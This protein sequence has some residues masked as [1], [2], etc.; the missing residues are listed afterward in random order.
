VFSPDSRLLALPDEDTLRLYSCVSGKAVHT[1]RVPGAVFL[2]AAFAPDGL[3]LA[4]GD[5]DGKLYLWERDTG[6]AV[7]TWQGH[8]FAV[9]A[10]AFAA[11]GR[12]LVS[13]GQDGVIR[14]WDLASG[15]ERTHLDGESGWVY[16]VAFSPDGRT[17]ASGHYNG[18]ALLWDVG[19]SPEGPRRTMPRGGER[20]ALWADL[21]GTDAAKAYRAG[22]VLR[23]GGDSAVALL[24]ERLRPS[25]PVSAERLRRLIADLD[26]ADFRTR[27]DASAELERLGVR[28]EA[29]LRE[30]LDH[31]PSLEARRRLEAL[32]QEA[33][34]RRFAFSAEEVGQRRAVAV[35]GHIGSQDARRLL[36][37]LAEGDPAARQTEAARAAL[38]RLEGRPHASP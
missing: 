20:D 10:L 9:Y 16:S 25:P 7:R 19:P 27:Q 30:A 2:T 3:T 14:L 23:E 17:L 5:L 15:R 26:S 34:R 11:D 24:R 32:L 29:A 35:L 21:T 28:T 37:R 36:Q 33:R 38:R 4:A 6:Q 31:P 13:A 1:A 8:K 12:T 18:T 22:W